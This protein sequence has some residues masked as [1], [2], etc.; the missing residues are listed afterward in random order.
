MGRTAST[1]TYLIAL[2]F[3]F[4]SSNGSVLETDAN[5]A[6]LAFFFTS[7]SDATGLALAGI[8]NLNN[9]RASYQKCSI[10]MPLPKSLTKFNFL[11]SYNINELK[12]GT[13]L[14][15]TSLLE[16]FSSGPPTSSI[17]LIRPL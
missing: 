17:H 16:P 3:R 4:S 5:L 13:K 8:P 7:S 11:K 2:A 12:R 1:N 15:L 14:N 10:K 6:S 9:N